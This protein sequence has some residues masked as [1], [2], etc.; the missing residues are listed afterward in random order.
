MAS[1]I[2]YWI[3]RILTI[4]SI[5]F[6]TMF[7]F[8]V[9]GGNESFGMKMLGFLIHNI[10]VLILIAILIIAWKW[11]AAGG[12]LFILASITGTLF[13]HSFSGN[14]GSLI[15]ISPFLLTGILFILHYVFYGRNPLSKN[16]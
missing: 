2:L 14:P 9:F 16:E 12:A 7:S 1:K 11:E 13:F 4:L 5:L 3:P 10:P 6:M 15:V 8:D